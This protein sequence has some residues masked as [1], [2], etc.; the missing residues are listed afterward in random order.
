MTTRPSAPT[1]KE[2][3]VLEQIY[4]RDNVRQRDL[5]HVI[6][7]SLGM[8]NA[9]LKRLVHKGFLSV[10]KVNNRNIVYAVSPVGAEE[11][12][13][14]SYRYLK[15]TIRHV[16]DYK[17]AIERVVSTVAAAGYGALALVGES[18]LDF[19]VEHLCTKQGISFR[20]IRNGDAAGGGT[21]RAWTI[22]EPSTFVL[23]SEDAGRPEAGLERASGVDLSGG[24]ASLRD[25]LI[26][27]T[28]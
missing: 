18:E 25:I 19:I 24:R 12:A 23:Y 17:Q 16:V 1:E 13:R 21:G 4:L 27:E 9:I 26:G 14:R 8:T 20:R 11:L 28:E 5:A 7:M 3:E 2:L 15:R 6:G 22:G 10:R